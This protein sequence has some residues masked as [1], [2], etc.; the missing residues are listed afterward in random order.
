MTARV[1]Q[2]AFAAILRISPTP[3][4]L[5]HTS[6]ILKRLRSF[7]EVKS[8]KKTAAQTDSRTSSEGA[9]VEGIAYR[10]VFSTEDDL[11]QALAAGSFTV[12]VDHDLA[13]PEVLDPY[14]VFG[15]QDRK[16]PEPKTFTCQLRREPND[17]SSCFTSIS[18]GKTAVA[19]SNYKLVVDERSGPLYKSLLETDVPLGQLDGLAAAI[20]P[21]SPEDIVPQPKPPRLMEMY[22]SAVRSKEMA[23][24]PDW[25][26]IRRTKHDEKTFTY[27]KAGR[28]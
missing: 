10:T 25:P 5:V 9:I 20:D 8:F 23:L 16:H 1:A 4:S 22:R 19:P 24:Q 15:L 13:R 3:T 18:P 14:N 26:L 28:S 2:P 12:D 21:V 27:L 11:N 17:D 7:G 6:P